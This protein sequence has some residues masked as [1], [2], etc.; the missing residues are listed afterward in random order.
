VGAIP[1]SQQRANPGAGNVNGTGKQ[2]IV[3]R[4]SAGQLSPVDLDVDA[5]LLAVF[6]DQVLIAHH[7]EQQVDNAEL[8]GDTDL[9]F[10][11]GHGGCDQAAGKQTQAQAYTGSDGF[12]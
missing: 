3:D 8:F 6:L 4:R 9:A 5:L 10:G 2:G 1:D 7:V 12:E 11:M